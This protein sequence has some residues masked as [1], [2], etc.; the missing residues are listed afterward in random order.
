MK[1]SSVHPRA[2][3]LAGV[4]LLLQA[5][6]QNAQGRA[7]ECTLSAIHHDRQPQPPRLAASP[8]PGAPSAP[9]RVTS[10]VHSLSSFLAAPAPEGSARVD[11]DDALARFVLLPHLRVERIRVG[12]H[13]EAVLHR[14][15]ERLD[16]APPDLFRKG[17]QHLAQLGLPA[18]LALVR[19]YQPRKLLHVDEHGHERHRRLVTQRPAV[20]G[21]RD[22]HNRRRPPLV[23]AHDCRRA[24]GGARTRAVL[25][26][27]VVELQ[28][29]PC[30]AGARVGA[31][32]QRLR[33]D[34]AVRARQDARAAPARHVEQVCHL[35]HVVEVAPPAHTKRTDSAAE[36]SFEVQTRTRRALGLAK[37]R[38]RKPSKDEALGRVSER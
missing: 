22:R 20:V 35:A 28:H 5:P 10:C 26:H 24:I 8:L 12:A 6:P 4:T 23:A 2:R 13:L 37:S 32:Q 18:V 19:A 1:R 25:T 7:R 31:Q 27:V 3:E 21:A 34:A 16:G 29:G 30:L 36:K 15:V 38:G 33:L 9:S 14:H 17:R 11:G